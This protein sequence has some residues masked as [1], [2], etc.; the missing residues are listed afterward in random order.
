MD[1]FSASGVP[2]R[3]AACSGVT[4]VLASV[5]IT[6]KPISQTRCQPVGDSGQKRNAK[7]G[8]I[9][10]LSKAKTLKDPT[11]EGPELI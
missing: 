4:G 7:N 10:M 2:H 5:Q 8:G 1:P 9:I 11:P 6:V 3:E